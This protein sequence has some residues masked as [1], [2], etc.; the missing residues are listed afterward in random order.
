ML[1]FLLEEPNIT[2]LNSNEKGCLT[3]RI[4]N[5]VR[6]CGEI[7]NRNSEAFCS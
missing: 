4:E 7:I 5:R 1:L 2:N 6:D 3:V